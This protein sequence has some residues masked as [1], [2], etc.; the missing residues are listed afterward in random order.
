MYL[1][2]IKQFFYIVGGAYILSPFLF[3]NS[4]PSFLDQQW[5]ELLRYRK[6]FLG[7]YLSEQDS[8]SF[9]LTKNGK[10]SPE[11]EYLEFIKKSK[12]KFSQDHVACKFPARLAYLIK[13]KAIPSEKANLVKN[14]VEFQKFKNKI[15]PKSVS[16]EFSSYYINKPASAFGHTLMRFSKR[17][18]SK[19]GRDLELLDNGLNYS[20]TVT[21]NNALLYGIYGIVGLFKGQFLTL[22][23]FYKVRE[24]ND[25]EA[26]DLWI[27]ELNLSEEQLNFL[28]AHTWEMGKAYFDYFY[29][30]E[31]CSYHL[32]ALLN[33][34]NPEWNLVKNTG[35]FVI[36]VDTIKVIAR[37]PGLIKDIYFRPSSL[38][39]F[40]SFEESLKSEEKK[41]FKNFINN[42]FNYSLIENTPQKT[43][44]SILD[45]A[46]AY[47][48]YKY[49]DEILNEKGQKNDLKRELLIK[50]AETGVVTKAKITPFRKEDSPHLGHDS[51]KFSLGYFDSEMMGEGLNILHRFSLHDFLDS[52][53][54]HMKSARIEMGTVQLKVFEDEK[55]DQK[56]FL[57][58]F[59]I[60]RVQAFSPITA[61]EAP[62]SFKL[63]FGQKRERDEECDFC[64]IYHLEIAPGVTVRILKN[65]FIYGFTSLDLQYAPK[66]SK[67]HGRALAGFDAGLYFPMT[68]W[69]KLNMGYEKRWSEFSEL[70][71]NESLLSQIQYNYK[72]DWSILGDFRKFKFDEEFSLAFNYYY[73]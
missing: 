39:T 6:T 20:A 62:L 8:P 46:L 53:K 33:A 27:Y 57:D 61:Y 32:L 64:T 2:L 3:A 35:T 47:L 45:S 72:Q 25:N 68:D 37:T 48:D 19:N 66:L 65:L 51:R 23:Y 69:L 17:G 56:L 63:N 24:Y 29:F 58:Q 52:G 54:G 73:Q 5:L 13:R 22:P 70:K 28:V 16:L 49:S 43:K 50:R 26:R 59:Y 12:D 10:E 11:S 21:T 41:K 40:K 60:A 14:C 42:E 34:V 44:A 15:R 36:P 1:R 9:F 55:R 67:N 38:K 31:N 7:N 71:A 30:S 18:F 4:P